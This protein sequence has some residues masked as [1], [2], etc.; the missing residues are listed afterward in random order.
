M[1]LTTVIHH[2]V[3]AVNVLEKDAAVRKCHHLLHHVMG[4]NIILLWK[5]FR[6]QIHLSNWHMLEFFFFCCC[7]FVLLLSNWNSL[8]FSGNANFCVVSTSCDVVSN[9]AWIIIWFSTAYVKLARSIEISLK[10]VKYFLYCYIFRHISS[11]I[12]L[13]LCYS[14]HCFPWLLLAYF[15]IVEYF[16]KKII[17][18][19]V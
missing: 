16:W 5:L 2:S 13:Y 17:T 19:L 4:K 18:C 9:S 14:Q 10:D 11:H 6:R 12:Y 1:D 8:F 3:T 7:S 15:I